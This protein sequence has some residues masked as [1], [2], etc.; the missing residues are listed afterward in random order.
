M[1]SGEVVVVVVVEVLVVEGGATLVVVVEEVVVV[2]VG[3]NMQ[4]D[5][6]GPLQHLQS[7][8]GSAESQ[9]FFGGGQSAAQI[10]PC[11]PQVSNWTAET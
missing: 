5:D 9:S 4:W 11:S 3:V 8:A 6:P 7:D 2:V 1:L 10:P